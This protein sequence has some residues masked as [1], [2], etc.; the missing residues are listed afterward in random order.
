VEDFTRAIRS[1]CNSGVD[2][3]C[4]EYVNRANAY[5]KLK[6]FSVAADDLSMAIR[7]H[8][9]AS[10][11]WGISQ[12]RKVYPEY[13]NVR[14]DVLADLLRR[15]LFPQMTYP[16]FSKAFLIDAKGIDEFVIAE[17]YCKRGDM[18]ARMG[19]GTDARKDYDRVVRGFP[20]S[21]KMYLVEHNGRWIRKPDSD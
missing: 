2:K 6:N 13:D 12:F 3:Q 21:A 20:E 19:D 8:L 16:D 4:D 1:L 14:D 9:G 18:Y 11:I 17:L 5:A 15:R 7:S 10:F